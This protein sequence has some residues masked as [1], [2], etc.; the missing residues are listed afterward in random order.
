MFQRADIF[1]LISAFAAF[2]FANHLWFTVDAK[3]GLFVGLWVPSNLIL[4]MYFRRV[5][6]TSERRKGR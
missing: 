2:L 4:A 3:A 1:F 5:S 6:T